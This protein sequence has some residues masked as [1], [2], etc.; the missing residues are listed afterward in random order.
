MSAESPF[1]RPQGRHGLYLAEYPDA[2]DKL[3]A[4]KARLRDALSLI[5]RGPDALYGDE[6]WSAGIAAQA[7]AD[8]RGE[9]AT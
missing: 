6:P 1:D 5:T 7:L 8:K 4:E 3:L 2:Y 9:Q